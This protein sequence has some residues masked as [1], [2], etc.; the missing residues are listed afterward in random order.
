MNAD[1]PHF[2]KEKQCGEN[3]YI[4]ICQKVLHF[5]YFLSEAKSAL[6]LEN[7]ALDLASHSLSHRRWGIIIG[8]PMRHLLSQ[9][10]QQHI[11]SSTRMNSHATG[12]HCLNSC[13]AN[14]A[15][16]NGDD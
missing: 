4:L 5:L 6:G 2:V 7:R 9:M 15:V 12:K 13:L 1:S 16:I 14:R 10:F 11:N 3:Y 8:Q